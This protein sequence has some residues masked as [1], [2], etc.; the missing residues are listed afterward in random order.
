[1]T[2][3]REYATES[4]AIEGARQQARESAAGLGE[5]DGATVLLD[6]GDTLQI[7]STPAG[8][9]TERR[10][11][12]WATSGLLHCGPVASRVGVMP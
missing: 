6:C 5:D 8:E 9:L 11:A 4:E 10:A 2:S 12:G 3:F 7:D 1:M